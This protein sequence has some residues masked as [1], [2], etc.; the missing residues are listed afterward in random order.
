VVNVDVLNGELTFHFTR[1]RADKRE[2]ETVA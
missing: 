1:D 2:S